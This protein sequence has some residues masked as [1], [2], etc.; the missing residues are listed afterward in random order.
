M[1]IQYLN[2]HQYEV[3]K[4][5]DLMQ[6]IQ[7]Q[8]VTQ[9]KAFFND[10]YEFSF[11]SMRSNNYTSDQFF[12]VYFNIHNSSKTHLFPSKSNILMTLTL[13]VALNISDIKFVRQ[14]I[15]S[16]STDDEYDILMIFIMK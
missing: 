5:K 1:S 3:Y 9:D 4:M 8:E 15:S 10:K 7:F 11:Q 16:F 12:F 2:E 14:I 6:D 13:S